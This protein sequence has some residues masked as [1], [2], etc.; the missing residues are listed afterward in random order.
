MLENKVAVLTGA[1]NE[2]GQEIANAL[3]NKGA[4]LTITDSDMKKLEIVG[5]DLKSAGRDFIMSECDLKNYGQVE[6]MVKQTIDKFGK[7]DILITNPYT[8]KLSSFVDMTEEIW[9]EVIDSN[10]KGTFHCCKAIVPILKNQNSGRIVIIISLAGY[11]GSVVQEG[12]N[13]VHFCTSQA[14][15]LGFTRTIAAE[16]GKKNIT[17]NAIVYGGFD[18]S[19]LR[20]TYPGDIIEKIP[21]LSN[22]GRA[23]K[24]E[25]IVAP[26]LFLLSDGAAFVNGETMCVCG[27]A[28]MR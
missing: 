25:D 1:A 8:N 27:G 22:I 10:L 6:S 21:S 24:P 28:F 20:E 15:L 7:I 13:D 2:I 4:N 16:V 3:A 5:K 26:V 23:G 12:T 19:S 17:A 18:Y 9:N 14:A 11:T